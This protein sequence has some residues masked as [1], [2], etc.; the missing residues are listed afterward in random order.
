MN[1]CVIRFGV[2]C[3]R[4]RSPVIC[5][6]ECCGNRRGSMSSGQVLAFH[7]QTWFLRRPVEALGFRRSSVQGMSCNLPLS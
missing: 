6:V 7:Q 5:A 4:G 3:P 2:S 1:S